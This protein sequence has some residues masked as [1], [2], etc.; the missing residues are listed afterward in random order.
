MTN[1][2]N[3]TKG[4]DVQLHITKA[5]KII[6]EYL[7]FNYVEQVLRK[8]PKDSSITKSIIRNVKKKHTTRID[9]INAMVEVA[10]E[11]KKQISK[12]KRLTT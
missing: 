6:D 5:Y 12:L 7:P 3:N 11:N 2:L 4:K 1:I 9:V 8:L 10:L